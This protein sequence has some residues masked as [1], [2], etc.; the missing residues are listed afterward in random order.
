[1]TKPSGGFP[2]YQAYASW[3]GTSLTQPRTVYPV[4]VHDF[5]QVNLSNYASLALVMTAHTGNSLVV[6]KWYL[7]QAQTQK[8]DQYTFAINGGDIANLVLPAVTP[9]VDIS[10]TV[11]SAGGQDLDVAF[12]PSNA[13][14]SGAAYAR[15]PASVGEIGKTLPASGSQN[16]SLGF[17]APGSAWWFIQPYDTAGKLQL[18]ILCRDENGAPK[19]WLV[20]NA[21]F[22]GPTSGFI[23]L[24]G[25]SVQATVT[26]NDGAAPH[27]YDF[28]FVA[29]GR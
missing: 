16:Y 17:I 12:T 19:Y 2:D 6:L 7:D 22:V 29:D 8:V 26:N 27:E 23:M 5:G 18:D 13:V 1:M 4:G 9:Y 15:T 28:T 11:T 20:K 25:Y 21:G 3:K 24:P 10:I 14:L